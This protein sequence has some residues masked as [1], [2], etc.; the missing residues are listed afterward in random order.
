MRQVK[1]WWVE[2]LSR[3][4]A[5]S[6]TALLK[7]PLHRL[8]LELGAK[9]V[10]FAGYDMP[11]QYPMGVLE[12]HKHCRNAAGLFDVSHMGQ[13]RLEGSGA[14][15][16]L[17]KIVPADVQ[18]LEKD[19]MRYTMFTSDSGGVLDDLIVLNRGD[20]LFLVVNAACKHEDLAL[21]REHLSGL[22]ISYLENRALLALQGPKA[23]NVMSRIAPNAAEMPF[24]SA[25][26]FEIAGFKCLVTRSGYTGEDGFEIGLE[27]NGAEAVARFLLDQEE[28]APIGLGARDSLRL[29]AGLCL[30]GHDLD[31][32]TSP[33]EAG[34][35]W[36]IG[37]RRRKDGG[38]RGYDRIN[39]E[40]T[41][42]PSR[43]RVGIR[44]D[45]RVIARE[46]VEIQADGHTIGTVTS[47]GFGPSSE[48]PIAM[49]Y[50]ASEFATIGRKVELLV[51]GQA[52]PGEIV[53]LPFHPHRY[54][55]G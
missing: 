30:Y 13:V 25:T 3:R 42:K 44:P 40:L 34:L 7:T 50:V 39:R 10:G 33:I 51:R 14:A 28:V 55:K 48:C 20:H 22:K 15:V 37:N 9:M 4:H 36:T 27:N 12:E 46:G 32:H 8:H 19:R 23:V 35:A 2:T 41:H 1:L 29:E 26:E 49:G 24:M 11:V 6:E 16:A 31:Q 17:E 45:G 43:R 21:M 18:G 47:G 53:K 38:F 5:L 54:F 52:R